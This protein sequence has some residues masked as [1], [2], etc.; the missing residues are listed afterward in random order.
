MRRFYEGVFGN[1]DITV[2]DE[3][4]AADI[5]DHNPAFPG[6]PAGLKGAKQVF[7]KVRMAFPDL[8]ITVEDAV[9]EGDKVV[10]RVTMRGTHKGEFA[11]IAPTGKQATMEVIEIARIAGGKIVERW[12]LFDEASLMRQ[13]GVVPA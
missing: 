4:V 11:G 13:L 5:V 2:A 9:A 6:L 3:F 8:R 12:G 10:S 1:G 7:S